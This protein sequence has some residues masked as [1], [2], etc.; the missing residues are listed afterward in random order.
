MVFSGKLYSVFVDSST[1]YPQGGDVP[2][3]VRQLLD[4]T[5]Q[6]QEMLKLWGQEQ[7]SENEIS[8]L[9]VQI[10]HEFNATISAFA[11]HRI[12]LR[13]VD[14]TSL[15]FGL[16]HIYYSSDIHD[17]PQDLRSVLERCLSEEP[18]QE[19]LDAYLPELREVLYRLLKGLQSRQEHWR[20]VVQQGSS[21]PLNGSYISTR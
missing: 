16:V 9:Y 21:P 1:A 18:C 7:I 11:Y 10:G 15:R 17:V 5:K 13:C 19:V 3:A 20:A 14:P 12:D 4:S 2:T 8:N 6:L